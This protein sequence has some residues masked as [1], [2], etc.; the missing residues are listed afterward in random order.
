M[1]NLS[2]FLCLFIVQLLMAQN[3]ITSNLGD[4]NEIKTYRG[5]TVELVKSDEQKIEIKGEKASDVVVKNING[6]LKISMSIVETFSADQVYVTVYFKHLDIIDSNEG[7]KIKSN[8]TFTQ[9]KLTVKSQEGGIVDLK[10]KTSYLDVKSI[11]GGILNITGSSDNQNVIANSGGVYNGG[12]LLTSYTNIAASTGA[13]CTV[14]ASKLVD[15]SAK[16][17]ATVTVTGNPQEVKKSES[18]GGYI[19]F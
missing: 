1:K 13:N 6:I 16:I 18:L 10:V 2:L 15:A 14:N 9:D 4:F 5:L 12:N 8:D 17:G 19:R 3:T 11:S 7:S